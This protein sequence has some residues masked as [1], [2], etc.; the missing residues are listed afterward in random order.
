MPSDFYAVLEV[1]RN[2]TD[3]EIKKAY[4]RLARQYHPDTN[5]GDP[6][7]EARFKEIGVA[8]ETLRDPEKRRRYDMYGAEGV[9]AGGGPGAGGFDFGVSDLFDAFFGGGFGGGRGPGGPPRGPDAEVH[10]ILDLEE[11]VFGVA[12]PVELRMPVECE[13]CSGSGCEPGTHPSTCRT[14]GGGGEVRT[15]RRTILGQMMTATPCAA[16]RGTGREILSPCRDCRG[17]GRVTLPATVEVQ[18]PAGIDDGQRLRL[19]GRGPA[20]PRGGEPGDLYVSIA[21]RPHPR[22]ERDGDDLLHVLRLP[23]TQAALGAHL[24]IETLDGGED[25]LIPTGTQTGRLFKLRGRGVPALRGRG[26]GD[27]VVSVE[28]VVPEKLSAEEAQL[29]RRL[30]ELRGEDVAPREEGFFSRIKSAFQ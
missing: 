7:A 23:M 16:C 25:L 29:V 24:R 20:G 27:L 8:Y 1:D 21:V 13:R 5:D 12:K 3:D 17:D 15:V 18:V 26:R 30:A 2:A 22:F 14:C 10:V 9:G 6:A 11:A 4:R 28:V 19:A